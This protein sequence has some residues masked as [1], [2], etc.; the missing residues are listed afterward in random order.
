MGELHLVLINPPDIGNRP[1]VANTGTLFLSNNQIVRCINP[2]ILSIASYIKS[3]G[4]EVEIIDLL[5]SLN[6]D[7]LVNGL[8]NKSPWLIGISC[9]NGFSYL[10]ALEC[11]KIARQICTD[12]MIVIG[13]QHVGPLGR[14]VLE[15]SQDIDVVVKFEGEIPVEELINHYGKYGKKLP[16]KS[17]QGIVYRDSEGV[18]NENKGISKLVDLDSM[19]YLDFELY[20]EY[21][22]YA[23][24]VEE[25]RGCSFQCNFC[26]SNYTNLSTIRIKSHQRFLDELK[27]TINLY[28]KEPIYPILA[29][30]FGTKFDNTKAIVNGLKDLGICWTTELRVDGLWKKIAEE[31]YRSGFRIATLGLESASPS[32]LLRMNKTRNPQKYL[33]HAQQMID[34]ASKFNEL[35]LKINII[36]YLGETPSTVRETLAFLM[37][38][39]NKLS[40]TRFSPLF[41]FPGSP[42]LT[43]FDRFEKLLGASLISDSFWGETHIYPVNISKYFKFQETSFLSNTLE[44]IF[45]NEEQYFFANQYT[46]G[47]E[48]TEKI[49]KTVIQGRYKSIEF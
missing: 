39:A 49:E 46:Y 31:M 4:K 8:A 36:F 27:H 19:P 25:S 13:G 7:K 12:S 40:A 16:P 30:T 35:L 34:I 45:T 6:L 26:L 1:P 9:S 38:N 20:P 47:L 23:P 29:S 48:N 5:D 28:G 24:Y 44:K 41:G 32:I 14:V 2:G 21:K 43:N 18:I 3:R 11:A 33:E 37:Q 22:K 10:S 42:F 17:V 15:D